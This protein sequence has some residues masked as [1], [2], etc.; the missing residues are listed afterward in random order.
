MS[1]NYDELTQAY[2]HQVYQGSWAHKRNLRDE[3]DLQKK[4]ICSV[5]GELH[6]FSVQK[7]LQRLNLTKHD[8]ML[9]LG[10]GLGKFALQVFMQSN[11][12]KMI[13]IEAI[14]EMHHK[15]NAAMTTVKAE[16]DYFWQPDRE[17]IFLN[18][19]F[20]TANW[21]DANIVY[22]CSTCFTQELLDA[23]GTKVNEVG[24]VK[25]VL[26]LRPIPTLKMPLHDIFGVECSWD[27][28]QCYHYSMFSN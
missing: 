18:E 10:S 20:L 26:S 13:G 21:H 12:G 5:Y 27:S 17:L 6:Y 4:L 15:A 24:Y 1:Y 7:I 14:T 28:T 25:Q 16:H 9:D 11:V 19:N 8:T 22:T 2:F 3:E 23:I